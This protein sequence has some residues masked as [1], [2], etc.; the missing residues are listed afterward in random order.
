[1]E[2]PFPTPAKLTDMVLYSTCF[3]LFVSPCNM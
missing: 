1:M 2:T 3:I